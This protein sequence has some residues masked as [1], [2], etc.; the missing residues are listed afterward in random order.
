MKSTISPK[1]QVTVPVRVRRQLGLQP[2]TVVLFEL[3]ERGVLMRK[4]S[5]G[6]H[7]VDR[8]YGML[9]LPPVDELLDAMRGPRPRRP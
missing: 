4:G 1:G 5:P 2:G 9:K 7:P 6:R 8:A 3:R